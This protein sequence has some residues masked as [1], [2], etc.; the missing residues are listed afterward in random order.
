[1][2][3]PNNQTKTISPVTTTE[4]SLIM[5][6]NENLEIRNVIYKNELQY[7]QGNTAKNYVNVTVL[8]Y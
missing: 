1:M 8:R 2:H 6:V 4:P 7:V 5:S 3:Q